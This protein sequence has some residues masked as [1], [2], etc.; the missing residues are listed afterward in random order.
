MLNIKENIGK[1]MPYLQKCLNVAKLCLDMLTGISFVFLYGRRAF[2]LWEE[3]NKGEVVDIAKGDMVSWG[4]Y[5]SVTFL[6]ILVYTY[7]GYH[8]AKSLFHIR[9]IKYHIFDFLLVWGWPL[10]VW[11]GLILYSALK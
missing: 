11:F 2:I 8:I 9:Q 3:L 10:F 7:I 5:C 6:E 1:V 4:V